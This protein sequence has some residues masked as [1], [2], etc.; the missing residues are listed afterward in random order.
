MPCLWQ[1]RDSEDVA[2]A[3]RPQDLVPLRLQVLR[4]QMLSPGL[5]FSDCRADVPDGQH[6]A[7]PVSMV[8]PCVGVRSWG[9]GLPCFPSLAAVLNPLYQEL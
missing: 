5:Q 7:M 8:M 1:P 4:L 9:E 2:P 6:R 3:H